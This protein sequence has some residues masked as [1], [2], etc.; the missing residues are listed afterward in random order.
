MRGMTNDSNSAS[1][2]SLARHAATGIALLL[3]AACATPAEPERM[4]VTQASGAGFPPKLQHAM[5][6]RKVTGGEATNP[7][8]VSEVDDAGFTEALSNSLD[9]V[10]LLGAQG[11]C[12]YFIDV[13]LLGLS[14]PTFGFTFEVTSHANYKVY[15]AGGKSALLA[16]IAG[17]YTADFAEAP[18]GSMRLKRANEGAIRASITQFLDRLRTMK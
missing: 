13:D 15:D 8:W 10:G 14:Q 7:L 5:C 2:A 3:L 17:A 1:V 16:T 12:R 9:S 6:V 11:S 4:A 18:L